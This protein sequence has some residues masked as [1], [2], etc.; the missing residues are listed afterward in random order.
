M[1]FISIYFLFREWFWKFFEYVFL[2]LVVLL[3]DLVC[4][5]YLGILWVFIEIVMCWVL[6]FFVD[7]VFNFFVVLEFGVI[8]LFCGVVI[9]FVEFDWSLLN[10]CL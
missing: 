2:F 7:D 3:I 9:K 8:V 4:V 6:D 10:F 1:L 5:G